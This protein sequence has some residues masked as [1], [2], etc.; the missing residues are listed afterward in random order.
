MTGGS[1]SCAGGDTAITSSTPATRAGIDV[2]QHGRRIGRAA[3]RHVD[4]DA[5]ERAARAAPGARRSRRGSVHE[6]SRWRAWKARMRRAA[7]R[8]SR[9]Q[10]SRAGRRSAAASRRG[11]TR[12]VARASK[13]TPSKRRGAARASA[14][15]PRGAHGAATMRRTAR[16][17]RRRRRRC[18]R[19][20]EPRPRRRRARRR[21]VRWTISVTP[22]IAPSRAARSRAE[23]RQLRLDALVAAIE[24][25]DARHPACCPAPTARRARA[26]RS[27]ADR[28]PSRARPTARPGRARRR[29][30]AV[31]AGC[32]RPCARAPARA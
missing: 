27:R 30:L 2:H 8:E 12:R 10:R 13:R 23:R 14:R 32:R 16:S 28:S 4:A 7:R 15:S 6:R 11:G 24:V 9:A 1:P 17:T 26:T 29:V 5:V 19:V 22:R 3:A 25:I 21:P 18:P 31:D 20:S